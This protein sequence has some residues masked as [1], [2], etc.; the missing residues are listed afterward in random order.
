MPILS[1]VLLSAE[2]GMLKLTANNFDE[3]QVETIDCLQGEIK[4]A[5]VSL[6]HLYSVIGGDFFELTQNADKLKIKLSFG[7]FDLK[8]MDATDFP[9]F[10]HGKVKGVGINCADISDSI[11]RVIWACGTGV[12]RPAYECVHIR[13]EPKSLFTES[14]D[15]KTIA[16]VSKG[17]M[18]SASDFMVINKVAKK[19]SEELLRTNAKF[20]TSESFAFVSHDNGEYACKLMDLKYP[21]TSI[22]LGGKTDLVGNFK[23]SELSDIF[24]RYIALDD[25]AMPKNAYIKT[26]SNGIKFHFD[27]KNSDSDCFIAGEFQTLEFIL[28]VDQTKNILQ[29]LKSEMVK[30]SVV[31]DGDS[32]NRLV[33]DDGIM[34][35]HSTTC[36]KT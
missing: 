12:Q 20:S 33:F 3:Y 23:V 29:N 8:T 27:G 22:L 5:C 14:C 10:N 17:L 9:A 11:A 7:S 1:T 24:G 13:S 15:G 6:G 34:I 18:C 31:M 2:S 26:D 28:N 36:K 21:D 25:P 4:P 35:A 16:S 19:L 30:I 32:V